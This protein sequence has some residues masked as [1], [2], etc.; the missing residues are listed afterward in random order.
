MKMK[1]LQKLL[2]AL[3]ALGMLIGLIVPAFAAE[4]AA[5]MIVA[6]EEEDVVPGEDSGEDI[7]PEPEPEPI[8]KEDQEIVVSQT[9]Y[10]KKLVKDKKF[11]L[12][13]E[14]WWGGSVL[15]Y[16]SSDKK[17]VTVSSD[18]IVTMKGEGSATVTITAPETE[19]YNKATV[20]VKITLTTAPLKLSPSSSYKKS[21]YYKALMKI[22]LTGKDDKDVAAVAK[23]Q[24]GY[25]E[26]KNK[27]SLDG[28]GSS[29]KDYTE[30]GRFCGINGVGW[31]SL[32]VNWVLR[33]ADVSESIVPTC[34]SSGSFY[35]FFHEKGQK[36]YSWSKIK[37]KSYQPK[38]GDIIFY[39]S[40]K[41]GS[42]SHMGIVV[43]ASY[44][45]KKV[46]LTT[47]EGNFSNKVTKR[48][49]NLSRSG[50]GKDSGMYIL[51]VG[52]PKY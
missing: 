27:S 22:K 51:G 36:Y 10:Q 50:S 46:K 45:D 18:G 34:H 11:S 40:S 38:A 4:S 42:T 26:G 35:S 41:D 48:T 2:A 15:K 9:S 24:V 30:Y 44:T 5:P 12:G 25:H 8:E 13:A 39:S 29:K 23:S 21:K 16:K 19:E 3:L 17:V 32:F 7:E 6:Q 43:G 37:K 47:V 52:H 28:S 14:I 20:K 33:E 49:M 1:I 31:C